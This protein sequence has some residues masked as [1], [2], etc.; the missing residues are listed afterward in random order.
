M[1][2]FI[3][4]ASHSITQIRIP[5]LPLFLHLL[6]AN[7]PQRVSKPSLTL[8]RDPTTCPPIYPSNGSWRRVSR[9]ILKDRRTFLRPCR[10]SRLRSIILYC[11]SVCTT[12]LEGRVT[13]S[14]IRFR[15]NVVGQVESRTSIFSATPPG[16][17][18]HGRLVRRGTGITGLG[19]DSGDVT[20]S[21]RLGSFRRVQPSLFLSLKTSRAFSSAFR[22]ASSDRLLDRPSVRNS[23][24]FRDWRPKRCFGS[25][26]RD[27]LLLANYHYFDRLFNLSRVVE[28]DIRIFVF[29]SSKFRT[30]CWKFK[31]ILKRWEISKWSSNREIR[32]SNVLKMLYNF[33]N[34]KDSIKS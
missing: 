1:F 21:A 19:A 25:V 23:F 7:D 13:V 30:R 26:L 8:V 14:G 11:G 2:P 10:V 18:R 6:R 15:G 31:K 34:V 33:G 24:T 28:V 4:P 16:I 29:D 3:N 9:M 27:S 20:R 22:F 12:I 32:F 5:I 17:K